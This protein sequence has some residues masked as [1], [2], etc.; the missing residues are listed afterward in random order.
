LIDYF[1]QISETI[2]VVCFLSGFPLSGA[3][4]IVVSE[5]KRCFIY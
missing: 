3:F 2:G 4:L 1:V 5:W